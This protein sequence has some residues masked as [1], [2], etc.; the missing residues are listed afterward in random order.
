LENAVKDCFDDSQTSAARHD[1]PESLTKILENALDRLSENVQQADP[2]SARQLTFDLSTFRYLLDQ[3]DENYMTLYE[4]GKTTRRISLFCADPAE[5]LAESYK[6]CRSAVLFSAT[7]TPYVFYK[8]LCGLSEETPVLSLPSPFPPEHLAVFHF[9]ADI[10]YSAREATLPTVADAI[11]AFVGARK[12]G[13]YLVFAPSHAYLSKLSPLLCEKLADAILIEQSPGM[14]DA[15]RAGFLSRFQADAATV[16]VG[17]AVMGG[18]FSEG[19]DLPAERLC[20]AVIIGV[21][22]PQLCLERN[23]L[24]DAYEEKYAQGYRYAYQ[25]PGVC[26]VLQAAGRI[27][28]TETDLGALLLVDERYGYAEYRNLLPQSWQL[29]RVRNVPQMVDALRT[30]WN[31]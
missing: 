5:K 24:R 31:E 8:T 28:R 25:Y 26:K 15:S 11:A 27:I 17:L 7:L 13:N 21:G 29:Q 20:G 3:Y 6:K 18:I 12:H 23:V 22:L 10:R 1:A 2:G 14:D 9:P 19:I 4:G 16:T 30:F